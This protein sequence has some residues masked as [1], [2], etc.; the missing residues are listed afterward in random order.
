M[1]YQSCYRIWYIVISTRTH[2]IIWLPRCSSGSQITDR[3]RAQQCHRIPIIERN[4]PSEEMSVCCAVWRLLGLSIQQ[5]IAVIYCRVKSRLHYIPI[6]YTCSIWHCFN[7]P[8][9]YCHKQI[10]HHIPMHSISHNNVWRTMSQLYIIAY[11][12]IKYLN[13]YIMQ[14]PE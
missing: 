10:K 12:C 3:C 4:L 2:I 11:N 8:Q 13:T 14:Q 1:V 9:S 6:S 5:G 7:L